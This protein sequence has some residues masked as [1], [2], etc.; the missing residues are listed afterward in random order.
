ML[1]PGQ[2]LAVEFTLRS[3]TTGAAADAD[4]TPTG[5]LIRNGVATAVSVTIT[6]TSTGIYKASA[7]VPANYAAGDIVQLRITATV[8]SIGDAFPIWGESLS[9]LGDIDGFTSEEASR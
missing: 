5:L 3:P 2:T 4:S 1:V 7:V 6:H 8:E 9:T